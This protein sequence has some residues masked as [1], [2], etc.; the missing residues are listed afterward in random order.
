MNS[1]AYVGG[2]PVNFTDPTGMM[3]H[4]IRDEIGVTG[5]RPPRQRIIIY[6]MT[7]VFDMRG[8][9]ESLEAAIMGRLCAK[10]VTVKQD[11]DNV[12]IN[13]DVSFTGSQNNAANR[14]AI[15]SSIQDR[16]SGQFGRYNTTTTVGTG[17]WPY[18]GVEVSL[19]SG[20]GRPQFNARLNVI[21]MFPQDTLAI[22]AHEAGHP[23]GLQDRYTDNANGTFTDDSGFEGNIMASGTDGTV[24]EADIA[25]IVAGCRS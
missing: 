3:Q 15:I 20:D 11:G 9:M 18:N 5:Q 2:D 21:H 23:F 19:L 4:P 7:F 25:N 22:A 1:Q 10:G 8:F 6:V 17:L 12:S 14:S 13:M 16:W 24:S